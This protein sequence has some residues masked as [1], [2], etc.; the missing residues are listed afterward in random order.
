MTIAERLV[1]RSN[2]D[3]IYVGELVGR[4]YGTEFGE[5]IRALINGLITKELSMKDVRFAEG[6]LLGRCEG[7]QEVINN[8]EQMIAEAEA[9]KMPVEEE[10]EEEIY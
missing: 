2:E 5:V 8:I 6:R 9:L 10:R 1:R 4:V 7:Y 3:K